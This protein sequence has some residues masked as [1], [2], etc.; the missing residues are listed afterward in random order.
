M[1]KLVIVACLLCAGCSGGF[2]EG[3]LIGGGSSVAVT[4]GQK[5]AQAKKSELVAEIVQLRVEQENAIDPD[6]IKQLE[7]R[8][9]TAEKQKMIADVAETASN[10]ALEGLQKDWGTKDPQKQQENMMWVYGLVGSLLFGGNELRKRKG[11]EK[12][13]QRLESEASPE[14]AKRI[15]DTVKHYTKRIVP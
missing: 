2:T 12:G 11:F 3:I 10:I 5:L 7:A 1:K 14:E 13:V 8:L 6:E 4:E 9:A 15:H